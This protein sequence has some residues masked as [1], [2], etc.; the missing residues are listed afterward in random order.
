M[1]EH[2]MTL[3]EMLDQMTREAAERGVT[4]DDY[5]G[6]LVTPESIQEFVER[7]APPDTGRF[8]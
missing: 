1:T 7:I 6:S 3:K 5:F 4:L 2:P 8:T